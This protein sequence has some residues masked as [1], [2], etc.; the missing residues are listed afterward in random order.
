MAT[1]K[2]TR[3]DRKKVALKRDIQKQKQIKMY[4]SDEC[5]QYLLFLRQ[6]EQF[7]DKGTAEILRS[8]LKTISL[9]ISDQIKQQ[10]ADKE[11]IEAVKAEVQDDE[12][13]SE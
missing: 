8:C 4:I 3:A 12:H 5:A 9:T 2:K 6:L 11:E 10:K 7:K 1:K 13:I